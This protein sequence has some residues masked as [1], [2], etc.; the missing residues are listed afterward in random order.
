MTH[1][2]SKMIHIRA[3]EFFK[4]FSLISGDGYFFIKTYFRHQKIS[5]FLLHLG[6]ILT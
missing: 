1:S 3:S 6:Y 4:D 2:S 5:I